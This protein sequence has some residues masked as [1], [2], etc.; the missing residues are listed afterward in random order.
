MT[1]SFSFSADNQKATERLGTALATAL[2]P[3]DTVGLVGTLGSGKT[4][5]VQGIAAACGVDVRSV[6]S[7]TYV[8]LHEYPGSVPLFHFDLY[9]VAD[10]DEWAEL[11]AEETF[12]QGGIVLIEW[13][14]RFRECMPDAWLEIAIEILGEEQ[15]CFTC[16]GH[17]PQYEETINALRSCLSP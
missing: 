7:P 10:H 12:E 2:R 3:G 4:R 14:D 6:V 13:A 8:I 11:G 1:H 15:R 17:G 9:R 16:I 5:L